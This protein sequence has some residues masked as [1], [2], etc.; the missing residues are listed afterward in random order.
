MSEPL[1]ASV[2]FGTSHRDAFLELLRQVAG[3]VATDW[4]SEV[5]RDVLISFH[6]AAEPPFAGRNGNGG[7]D[8]WGVAAIGNSKIG[9]E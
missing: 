5:G 1:E 9:A 3:V 8:T 2:E 7:R 4:K 6:S